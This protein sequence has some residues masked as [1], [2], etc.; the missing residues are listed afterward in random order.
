EVAR[1]IGLDVRPGQDDAFPSGAD[2]S[3]DGRI[4]EALGDAKTRIQATRV[5][6]LERQR[7][8]GWL[9]TARRR[10]RG[11]ARRRGR[12]CWR[13]ADRGW[14]DRG[15]YARWRN[16]RG[17]WWRHGLAGDRQKQRRRQEPKSDQEPACWSLRKSAMRAYSTRR[18]SGS[19]GSKRS[20]LIS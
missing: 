6:C 10:R 1:A 9:R 8:E 19:E 5:G 18:W 11:R 14:L 16:G 17:R 2:I 3:H 15:R 12:G 4:A 7:G 13:Y 20:W